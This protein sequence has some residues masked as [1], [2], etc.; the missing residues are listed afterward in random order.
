MSNNGIA[1]FAYNTKEIDY[2]K[3]SLLAA[4]F[5]KKHMKNNNICLII[6]EGTKS[7]MVNSFD[8]NF[9]ESCI[10]DFVIVDQ[11]TL[12]G[13]NKRLHY[14]SPYTKFFNEFYN[15]DK[16]KIYEYTP[17]DKTLLL[18]VDYIVHNDD[19]DQ[20]FESKDAV[21]MFHLSDNLKGEPAFY[22]DAFLSLNGIP[23][24][25]STVIY[26]D[27]TNPISKIFFD[28]WSYVYDN[29][30]YYKIVYGLKGDMYRTDYCVSIVTHILNGFQ[31]GNI[32]GDF[33][34]VSMR[35]MSQRDD[36]ININ[37]L[38]EW[39]FLSNDNEENWKDIPIKFS[40]NAHI[41]NKRALDRHWHTIMEMFDNDR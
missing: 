11:N 5:V 41:M 8:K 20:I 36:I 39:V 1:L 3:L 12:D 15:T 27:K 13:S 19:L 29:Y 38:D 40:E 16:H 2:A 21:S 9:V 22:N 34:G 26:F 30:D 14:D 4:K 28:T 10:D 37:D 24:I 7:Y 23:T 17:Y 25:W 31:Q 33:N 32:I 18:D 35:Y 6:D